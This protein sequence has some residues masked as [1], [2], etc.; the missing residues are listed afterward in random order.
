L[1]NNRKAHLN[2][3]C[4]EKVEEKDDKHPELVLVT[5]S[6]LIEHL[7]DG[8]SVVAFDLLGY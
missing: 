8:Q 6:R 2:E 3:S 5:A 4:K 1:E 7:G